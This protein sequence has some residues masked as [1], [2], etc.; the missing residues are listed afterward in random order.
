MGGLKRHFDGYGR[1]KASNALDSSSAS[2]GFFAPVRK[3]MD[4][5]RLT[6]SIL[7]IIVTGNLSFL[8]AENKSLVKL[9]G[10]A[11]P[12]CQPPNRRSVAL[13]LKREAELARMG[14][15]MRMEEIDSKVSIALDEWHS[16]V[17]NMDFLG[18]FWVE[19]DRRSCEREH[20]FIRTGADQI[21]NRLSNFKTL[22]L[23]HSRNHCS[24]G[25]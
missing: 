7:Q 16:K 4:N 24:L 21:I 19:G 8:Q 20:P 5:E 6:E 10:E 15:T 22:L 1:Y 12:T 25:R 9:L 2:G 3:P 13:R 11:F 17:G 23:T 14:L 18:M